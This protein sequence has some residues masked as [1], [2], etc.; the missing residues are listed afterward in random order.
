[1]RIH[2]NS[3]AL[4]YD[5]DISVTN[6]YS[7]LRNDC[8]IDDCERKEGEFTGRS[9]LIFFDRENNDN[10]KSYWGILVFMVFFNSS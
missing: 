8:G 3:W 5:N 1:M 9:E 6:E 7:F 2:P 10:I 4:R